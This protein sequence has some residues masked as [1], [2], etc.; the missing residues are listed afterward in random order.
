MFSAPADK[1]CSPVQ[2]EMFQTGRGVAENT[3]GT[4]ITVDQIYSVDYNKKIEA[5]RQKL[6]MPDSTTFNELVIRDGANV[7]WFTEFFTKI[8]PAVD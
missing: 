2:V 6:T 5:Y 4:V 8:L 1:K 3:N 7:S